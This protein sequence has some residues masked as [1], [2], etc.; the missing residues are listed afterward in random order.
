MKQKIDVDKFYEALTGMRES[1]DLYL[2]AFTVQA[3]LLRAK[4]NAL[5]KEGFTEREA[6]ELCK[7]PLIQ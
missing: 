1:Y 7:G 2:Q 6:L 4:Y 5:L 3:P